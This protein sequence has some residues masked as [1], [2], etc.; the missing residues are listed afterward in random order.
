MHR[1][2]LVLQQIGAG[3]PAKPVL[4]CARLRASA[5]VIWLQSRLQI[6]TR[7][8]KVRMS[9]FTDTI[10]A[11]SSGAGPRRRRGDPHLRTRGRDVAEGGRR[12]LPPPRHASLR[13]LRDPKP[14][15]LL[16]RGL[17]CVCRRPPPSPARTWSSSICMAAAQLS[18]A[19]WRAARDAGCSAAEAGRVHA[20]RLR[21][22]QARSHRGRGPRRSDR[23]RDGGAAAAGAGAAEGGAR[24]LCAA[25]RE[26]IWSRRGLDRS[27]ARLR[28]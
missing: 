9:T 17:V 15:D 20:P 26:R 10:F 2:V 6:A 23:R 7:G 4:A 25:W 8:R 22:R 1:I 24:A 28:R 3:L 11:L 16:D 19:S 27:R 14:G 5:S 21:Q 12:P 18:R 13:K